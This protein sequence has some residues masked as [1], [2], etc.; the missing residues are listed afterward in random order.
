MRRPTTTTIA[1]VGNFWQIHHMQSP[2]ELTL[3]HCLT[4]KLKLG[5]PN[6]LLTGPESVVSLI[7]SSFYHTNRFSNRFS[8][9][10]VG[11]SSVRQSQ[12]R[13]IFSLR[14]LRPLI[15]WSGC[16]L[17]KWVWNRGWY[18]TDIHKDAAIPSWRDCDLCDPLTYG[19][20][21]Q[22]DLI[23]I[24]Q[25]PRSRVICYPPRLQKT[26]Q[27]TQWNLR[28]TK[29][30]NPPFH[31]LQMKKKPSKSLNVQI[32]QLPI[33]PIC[34]PFFTFNLL[35]F[36]KKNTKQQVVLGFHPLSASPQKPQR[37][38][39]EVA[40]VKG[41]R[42]NDTKCHLETSPDFHPFQTRVQRQW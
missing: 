20:R 15:L 36:R 11:K 22:Q 21:L 17:W 19:V 35:N 8:C 10:F 31:E 14:F 18:N 4:E 5:W 23:Y 9:L 7:L 40:K 13:W 26:C 6:S 32:F 1:A 24:K 12:T 39:K 38:R 41:L 3:D 37:L 29:T 25:L 27:R 28:R 33:F 30:E 16:F 34:E 42:R 2:V